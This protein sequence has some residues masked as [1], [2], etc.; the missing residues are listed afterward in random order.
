MKN[1]FD[2]VI[3][4]GGLG[5]SVLAKS[6][7]EGGASVLVLERER[8]FKDRVRGE[9]VTSWGTAEA[10]RLGI[11]QML[12][13][14]VAHPVR[15]AD[16]YAVKTLIVHRDVVT[17]TPQQLPCL[18]FYHPAMQEVV[19]QAAADAGAQV[20][21]GVT[22]RQVRPGRPASITL[23]EDGRVD[24][25]TARLVVGADGRSSTVRSSAGFEMRVQRPQVLDGARISFDERHCGHV[26]N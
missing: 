22:A 26:H 23:G 24:E 8:E 18:A 4:G 25:V 6:M 16:L 12:L 14:K 21:R 2:L 7:A 19:L 17:T 15:W 20:R 10:Q 3:I 5:G 13:D 11:Y 1:S 9:F